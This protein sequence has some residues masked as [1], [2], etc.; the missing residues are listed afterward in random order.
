MTANSFGA[1][2]VMAD[3]DGMPHLTQSINI[4]AMPE[5]VWALI[6]RIATMT[7]WY[8]NWDRV[9]PATTDTHFRVGATFR[10]IRRHSGRGVA[11]AQCRVTEMSEFSRLQWEQSQPN[12]PTVSVTFE[13]L[14]NPADGTTELRQTRVWTSASA[15]VRTTH[16]E[17]GR[18]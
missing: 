17:E 8:D 3:R 2:G 14:P 16:Q 12:Q 5:S 1:R 10:L 6:A 15:A 18:R 11:T 4:D 7:D 13:L 9:E